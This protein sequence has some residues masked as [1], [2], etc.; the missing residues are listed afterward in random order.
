[1]AKPLPSR[2]SAALAGTAEPLRPHAREQHEAGETR[3]RG[4]RDWFGDVEDR[5][6]LAIWVDEPAVARLTFAS[7]HEPEGD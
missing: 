1:M 3:L 4:I 5:D 2:S 6:P 7:L